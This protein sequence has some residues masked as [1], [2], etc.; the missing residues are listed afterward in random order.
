MRAQIE[1]DVVCPYRRLNSGLKRKAKKKIQMQG[2]LRVLERDNVTAKKIS[3]WRKNVQKDPGYIE[4][5]RGQSDKK[6]GI[7]K[8]SVCK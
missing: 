5:E 8:V 1:R 3:T 6:K 4:C 7:Q 2:Y